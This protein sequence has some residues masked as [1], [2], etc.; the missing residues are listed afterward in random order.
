MNLRERMGEELAI[1][2]DGRVRGPLLDRILALVA[3][4]RSALVEALVEVRECIEMY[5]DIEDGTDGPRPNTA[6]RA[7]QIIDVVL[8][9][10]KETP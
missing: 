2:P 5:V 4:D 1:I 10:G 6:M 7:Q 9:S 8:A 3:Q